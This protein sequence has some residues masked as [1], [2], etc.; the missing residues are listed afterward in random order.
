MDVRLREWEARTRPVYS[1]DASVCEF[2]PGKTGEGSAV[3]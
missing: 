2:P 1:G 3:A